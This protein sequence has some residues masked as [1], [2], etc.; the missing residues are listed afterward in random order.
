MILR[1]LTPPWAFT[2]L[3]YEASAFGITAY[4]DAIP[5]NGNVPPMVTVVFVTPG[6]AAVV[7]PVVF[8]A[9]PATPITTAANTTNGSKRTRL[10]T[11]YA[12]FRTPAGLPPAPLE[13]N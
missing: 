1:P 10:L 4:A 9:A 3:K 6:V 12:S 11:F 5:L 2:H 8:A 13:R 7:L